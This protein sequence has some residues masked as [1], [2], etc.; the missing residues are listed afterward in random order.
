[1]LTGDALPIA[2]EVAGQAGLGEDITKLSNIK[3]HWGDQ[4]TL[5]SMEKS[6]GFAEVFPEDKYL[7]VKGLQA[8]GHFVG[9][10]VRGST[11]QAL[12]QAEVGIA[13]GDATGHR[14]SGVERRPHRGGLRGHPRHG[15]GRQDGLPSDNLVNDVRR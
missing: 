2:R 8:G 5:K 11:T 14:P 7:I 3:D 10:T 4:A 1:M 15:S 9:M 13:V 6:D 12:G